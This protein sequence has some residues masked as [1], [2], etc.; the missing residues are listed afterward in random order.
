MCMMLQ[1]IVK[2]NKSNDH[3]M[4]SVC[5]NSAMNAFLALL[6]LV[7]TPYFNSNA[8]IPKRFINQNALYGM[9]SLA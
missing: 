5:N 9:F 6:A 4:I 2:I 8:F 1:E 3:I 7:F